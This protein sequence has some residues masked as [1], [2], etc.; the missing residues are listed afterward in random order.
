MTDSMMKP[1]FGNGYAVEPIFTVG[2]TTEGDYTPVGVMDGIGAYELDGD[3]VRV[4]VNHELLN[5]AGSD[6]T[7]TQGTV[8]T[9]DDFTLTGSRISF[10][11]IDKDSLEIVDSGLA[12]NRIYDANGDL[13]EDA[14]FLSND[15]DGFSRFCSSA[16]FEAE[17]FGEGRGL[18]DRIYFTGEEDGGFFNGVGGAEWALNPDTG[19]LWQVPAMGRGAWENITEIDTGTTTHVAFILSDD[20]SPF[21]F[22]GDGEKEAAPLFMYVGEKGPSGDFLE[23][24]G[25]SDGTLYVWVPKNPKVDSPAEFNG[26]GALNGEWVALDMSLGAPSEFGDTGF[27]EYGYP[28]QSNL[29]LQAK[30]LGAF[31]FSRPED[32]STNPSNGSQFVLASTGV[33]NYDGGVDTFGTLYTMDVRFDKD[34]DPTGGVLKILYDGDADPDRSLRSPD[35][36]DWADDGYIYVQEDKAEDDTL[37]GEPLFGAGAINPAEAGIVKI[38]PHTGEVER[39]ATIDRSVVLDPTTSGTPVDQDAGVA[40]EWESSGILDVSTLFGYDPGELFIFD[41][42]AHGI[43]DQEGENAD[44]LISDGNLVEGGQLSFLFSPDVDLFEVEAIA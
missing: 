4:F 40:G 3:T 31:G 13:A 34:G 10:F 25:L 29:W 18:A 24:N 38:N 14:S 44:S 16:L 33:D 23:Q 9:G 22:D 1:V 42:Q 15:F 28:T 5:F 2:E 20:T 8:D 30:E 27:D 41:V 36:L 21:D 17:Q 19:E 26:Q 32:V 39:V 7:V 37:D 12:Y 43:V 6:Y 35:N 11:D